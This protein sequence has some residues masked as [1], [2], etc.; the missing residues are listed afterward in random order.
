MGLDM[1]R[2]GKIEIPP[3]RIKGMDQIAKLYQ[4][5]GKSKSEGGEG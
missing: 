4:L 2:K 1:F 3:K 5:T